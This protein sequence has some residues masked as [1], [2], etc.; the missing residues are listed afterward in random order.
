MTE[1]AIGLAGIAGLLLAL[2]LLG[3]PVGFAMAIVGF[4]GYAAIS[5]FDTA[6]HMTGQTLWTT[7]SMYGL[8]VIPLFTLM[9]Q[10]VFYSGVNEKL[11]AA[12]YNWIGHIRGGLAM[13]TIAACSAFATICGSNTATAATM[14][15]VALPQMKKFNYNPSFRPEL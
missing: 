11:Y 6:A 5:S 8:T 12:A 1:T 13:A 2:L 7:F 15:T 14:S 9:G 3:A 4:L 10:V